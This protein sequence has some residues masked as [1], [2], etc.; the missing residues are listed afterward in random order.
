MLNTEIDITPH[1][2]DMFC[3]CQSCRVHKG[4]TLHM[5]VPRSTIALFLQDEPDEIKYTPIET[6]KYV[7]R[8]FMSPPFVKYEYIKEED[9]L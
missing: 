9:Y 7:L 2:D 8:K 6:D 1:T 4:H 3:A 5:L